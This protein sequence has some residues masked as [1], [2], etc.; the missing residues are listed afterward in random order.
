MDQFGIHNTEDTMQTLAMALRICKY[1]D[2]YAHTII[3]L[4]FVQSLTLGKLIHLIVHE[5]ILLPW[6]IGDRN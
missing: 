1:I 4:T 5:I 3:A 6:C 2:A